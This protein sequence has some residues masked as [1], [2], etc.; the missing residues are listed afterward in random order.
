MTDTLAPDSLDAVE[1]IIRDAA[2]EGRAV[3]FA[4]SGST[5]VADGAAAPEIVVS[6]ENLTGVVSYEPDDMTLVVRP[7]TTLREVDAVLSKRAL[8]AVFPEQS[9]DR[10]VGGVVATGAAGYRRLRYGPTRDR[11]LGVSLVTGYGKQISG[12][13][14]LVKNVTGYDLPRLVTGSYGSLGFIGE[15]CVKLLPDPPE[16]RTVP[17]RDIRDAI[18][19]VYRPVAALETEA[20]SFVYLSGTDRSLQPTLDALGARGTGGFVWPDPMGDPY[21]VSVRV[22]PREVSTAIGVVR[23]IGASRFVGQHGVGV[24]EAGFGSLTD[25]D[26]SDLRTATRETGGVVVVLRWQGPVTD[27]WGHVPRAVGI[28]TRLRNLFDPA[29]ILDHGQLPGGE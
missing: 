29:G 8:S 6:S 26:L 28:Q 10:T 11:V 9:P 7:G 12:G 23:G 24:V 2:R 14:R 20:G 21:L 18:A 22:P 15:V 25:H 17:V 13:G 1:Q 16:A 5:A 4:G 27:R 3:T 19:D